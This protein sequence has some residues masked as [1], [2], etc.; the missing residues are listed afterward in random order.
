M[1]LPWHRLHL[2]SLHAINSKFIAIFII[3]LYIH[4]T[5]KVRLLAMCTKYL[6]V[7]WINGLGL[8]AGG[9]SPVTWKAPI[10]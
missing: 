4:L 5:E 1:T 10:L 9:H 2:I 8:G 3:L 7:S 6:S